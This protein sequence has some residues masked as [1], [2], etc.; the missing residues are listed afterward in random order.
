MDV[1]ERQGENMNH[2]VNDKLYIRN[3][4]HADID[5]IIEEE[6]KQGWH[7]TKDKYLSRLNDANQK[8]C[9]SLVAI[10]DH[11]V[12]G[13]INLY[14]DK[15]N[16]PY[17]ETTIPEIIDLGVFKPYRK[18]G[19]AT[20]LIDVVEKLARTYSKQIYL[21]VGLHEGYGSAQRLYVKKGYIPDGNGAY[22][23][24]SIAAQYD[25]YPLDDDLVI[26]MIKEL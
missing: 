26:Y 22:Y 15:K 6:I 13:Y 4:T 20:A 5:V 8:Y 9:I 7:P 24:D 25:T 16:G 23:K 2:I 14:V 21:A 18:L 10:Y 12:A 1:Y 3:L 19:I 11:Q 17:K